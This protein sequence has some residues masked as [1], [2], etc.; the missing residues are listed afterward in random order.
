MLMPAI[1]REP[2]DRHVLRRVDAAAGG[3]AQARLLLGERDQF[4]ERGDAERRMR[5]EHDRLARQ[6]DDR[7]QVL[8]R[9]DAPRIDVRIA[10]DRVGRHQHG[11]AVRRALRRGLDADVAVGPGLVLD[12]DLLAQACATGTRRPAAPRRRSSRPPETA[13]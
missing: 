13:R 2:L 12:E 8:G 5:G 3:V 4:G 9:V 10:G 1:L 7:Q 11:V 6:V